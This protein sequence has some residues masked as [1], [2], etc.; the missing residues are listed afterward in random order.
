MVHHC[1]NIL[2]YQQISISEF[3]TAL[4]H[5]YWLQISVTWGLLVQSRT[6]TESERQCLLHPHCHDWGTPWARP[7]TLTA[8]SGAAWWPTD[9]TVVSI[10]AL[11]TGPTDAQCS[12]QFHYSFIPHTS[13][14]VRWRTTG[15]TIGHI[16]KEKILKN[17]SAWEDIRLWAAADGPRQTSRGWAAGRRADQF[18]GVIHSDGARSQWR[19]TCWCVE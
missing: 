1:K 7:L 16:L 13:V 12:I 18:P 9:G 4:L 2:L 5:Q 10:V 19:P 6:V 14:C 17:A 11:C 3:L 8:V 15:D